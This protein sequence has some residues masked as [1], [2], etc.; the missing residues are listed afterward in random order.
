MSAEFTVMMMGPEA[1]GKTTLLATMYKELAKIESY[2]RFTFYADN[3]TGINL[4]N[5]YQKL[6]RIIEQPVFTSIKPLLEGTRGIIYHRFGINFKDKK[7]LDLLF[8]D[9]AGGLINVSATD[10]DFKMFQ[11]QLNR[12]SVIINVIDGA[13][14]MEGS[15]FLSDNINKPSRIKDLLIPALNHKQNHLILFVITKCETWLN[16]NDGRARLMK[17]FDERFKEVINLIQDRPNAVGV[18]IPVK[19]LGCVEFSRMEKDG[20]EEKVIFLRRANKKFEPEFTDQP[21]RYAL[22][23][24]LSERDNNRKWWEKVFWGW[25]PSFKESL[26][27]FIQERDTTF[28]TYGNFQLIR[29]AR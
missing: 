28:K 7:E 12:A 13:V 10:Q 19:T 20:G 21:L 25:D 11:Q 14:L 22:A 23:F 2:A 29:I 5:A 18:V 15:N 1:V 26:F 4:D 8:C 27:Q 3:D 16:S 24:V 9:I 6:S 17:K